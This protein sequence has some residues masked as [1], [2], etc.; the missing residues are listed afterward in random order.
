MRRTNCHFCGYLCGFLATVEEGRVVDLQPDPTRYPY[1][2]QILAGCRRWRMNL[3]VLDGPDRVNYPLRRV[4]ARGS[5]QWERVSWEEALDDIAHRLRALAKAHGPETLASAIGGPHASYW[6]LHRFMNLFGSPNNMG[7]GQICWNPRIWMDTLTFGWTI[8]A[9][10]DP[11]ITECVFI[12][13]TN[14]AQSDNSMFWRSLIKVGRADDMTLVVIDPRRTQTAAVADMWIAP[15]PGTDCTLALGFLHVIIEEDLVDREFV[16][17]WC[18]GFDELAEHVQPYTPERVEDV[19]GVPA[20]QVRRAAQLFGSARASALVSGRGI[21]QVGRNVA[22]THRAI[23]CM[24]A[25]TGNIDKPGACVLTE[26]SDFATEVDLEMTDALAPEHKRRCLNTPYT[27]LQSYEGYERVRELTMKHRRRLP[28]R[29][30]TSAH[31]DLVLRAMETGE[32]YPV[33]ALV[34]EATNPL[35]TYAD[36]HRVFK[37]LVGLDLIVVLDYYLTSTASIADYVLPAAGAIERPLFQQHGGVANIAYGGPAAV[38]PYYERKSDYDVFR[39]LGLRLGQQEAWPHATFR[40]ALAAVLEPSGMSWED[41]CRTGLYFVPPAFGKHELPDAHGRPRGFATTTGKVELASEIL[42]ALGGQRLPEPGQPAR[43]CSQK[44]IDA[45]CAAG[46]AH[47]TMITGARKQPYNAS[48][49]FN[50]APFREKSPYP[51]AEMSE[52]TAARLGFAAGD[53]VKVAT[54]NGSARFI[55]ETKRM[56]DDLISVDY[57]WWHPE[58]EPGAP[59][60]GGIWESNVNCLT[61]CSLDAGEPLIGTWSYNNIDCVVTRELG[62]ADEFRRTWEYEG[63]PLRPIMGPSLK[64]KEEISV[65][66]EKKHALLLFSKP[67][68]P[69]MVKTRLTTK[70]G[71]FLSE[72]QAAEFFKR[73][74]YD[75]SEMA[76]HA[77]LQLQAENDELVK[78]DPEATKITYDFFVSTTPAD[79]VDLMRETYDAIG[80]WPMDIHYLTDKGATFDDH[81]DDAFAQIFALGYESIVSVGGDIPTMPKSHIVQAFEWLD[82]FQSLGTPGFV[83]A[84]CQE[85]GTSLV[86]FSYNTP[87]DHQGVYYNMDGVAALDAYVAKLQEKDIP[88]AYFSPIADIDERTDLA[89]AISCMRAIKEAAKHQ[90]DLFVPERVLAWVDYMGI[91]VSTPPNDEHDPRQYIDE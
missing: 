19:C 48:M 52:A 29:Y 22:P 24:R 63:K 13:G 76:M 69:G 86:G 38:E 90:A 23:C 70:H 30:M 40:E 50:Y 85:C 67:P 72:A 61:S 73:S 7:I 88:S 78:N 91:Q 51:V 28:T 8:E 81:F 6:P 21:D 3:D 36:T 64:R 57:G 41:Y 32:P 66:E 15:R 31:P 10:I 68:V 11:D 89:H 5:N 53:C 58:R 71:G 18:H 2:P 9:D 65:A 33:R 37:A 74:L 87:I 20:D 4:G 60:F 46:G 75:V 1:D 14:P 39:E 12:W 34:V 43:L 62:F 83:Q 17:A 44:L 82:Y 79:N 49:Y 42:P 54:D 59:D 56:R 45:A 80:P 27:P 84:P 77:L 47:L 55:L 35:L 25:I 26:M 16:N